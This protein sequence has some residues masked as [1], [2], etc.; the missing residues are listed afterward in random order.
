MRELYLQRSRSTQFWTPLCVYMV[1][2][3][4]VLVLSAYAHG[5]GYAGGHAA[6]AWLETSKAARV[7]VLHELRHLHETSATACSLPSTC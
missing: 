2:S 1:R 7:V 6:I 4:S 5:A 3:V